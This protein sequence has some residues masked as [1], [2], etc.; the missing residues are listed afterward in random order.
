MRTYIVFF[1]LWAL[2]SSMSINAQADGTSL[3]RMAER[4]RKFG[5]RI[6]Q[7][8]VYVHMDNTA[9]APGDTVWFKAYLRMTNTDCPSRVS[10]TLYVEL[11]DPDGYLKER[12]QVWM[13]GGEGDGYF[14][15]TDSTYFQGGFY[16]LRAYTRWQLNWGATEH[17][18]TPMAER[19]FFNKAAARDFFRD[20]EKLYSRVFPVYSEYE[21][22]GDALYP[23]MRTR[24]LMRRFR[25]EEAPAEPTLSLFPEG[26]NLVAGVQNLVAFEAATEDGKWLEGWL[27]VGEDSVR[28]VHRGRGTFL[29]TPQAGQQTRVTFTCADGRTVTASLDKPDETGVSLCVGAGS[30]GRT[31]LMRLA[32]SLDADSLAVTLMHEGRVEDFH[33]LSGL[34]LREGARV[35]SLD[36]AQ[37][38]GVHQLTVYDTRGRILADRLFFTAEAGDLQPTLTVSGQQE[39]YEPYAPVTL[40]LRGKAAGANVSVA[41]QS[42]RGAVELNDNGSIL[43]EMLLASEIR[44]FVPNAAWYFERDDEEHRA[45]LD[46]LMITQGWRRFPWREMALR[47]HFEIVHPAETTPV[48]TGAVHTYQAV[49]RFDPLLAEETVVTEKFMGTSKEE[50]S[51]ILNERFGFGDRWGRGLHRGKNLKEN[52]RADSINATK[53]LRKRLMEDGEKLRR[54]VRVRADYFHSHGGGINPG[55]NKSVSA[56]AQASGLMSEAARDARDWDAVWGE[57]TTRQG[58]FRLDL[59]VIDEFCHLTLAASDTTRWSKAERTGKKAHQWY[60]HDESDYPEFYIRLAFPYPNFVKP[61]T[62]YQTEA[63]VILPGKAG[64]SSQDTRMKEVSVTGRKRSRLLSRSVALPVVKMDAMEAYNM[65]VDMGLMNAWFASSYQFSTALARG[66]VSD[67]GQNRPYDIN[68]ILGQNQANLDE[69]GALEGQSPAAMIKK[70][71][72]LSMTDSV[73][74]YTDYAP[75]LEG[76]RRYRAANQP[77]VDIKVKLRLMPRD[78][79]VDRYMKLPGFA[80]TAEFYSPDYSRRKPAPREA[81]HRRTLYWNPYVPLNASGEATVSFFNNGH[82]AA[83]RVST[84]GQAADGTLL[85]NK[86][87]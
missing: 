84:Q 65:L 17:R 18:H 59:P 76:D 78:V 41:V 46:L 28:T 36:S 43:T 62:Y 81:D 69:L 77:E 34:P 52:C 70:A 21:E 83:I 64:G 67:M 50:I 14:A 40:T 31:A 20:Y 82:S 44:G 79:S 29:I 39:Y 75:R 30:T 10:K 42:G 72:L 61:Y 55:G 24:P 49:Q 53:E 35:L 27:R 47:G 3:Q 26:G 19:W 12:K 7:E 4:V 86:E 58:T 9:Y 73:F 25:H 23:V 22:V 1:C 11:R 85:W 80:R 48:L 38:A 63:R 13:T 87:E 54:E 32:G 57:T 8:K 37:A 56:S 71:G 16:E 15:L 45:A 6:P 68:F 33:V 60:W 51:R 5:A 74:V 2:A 66:L